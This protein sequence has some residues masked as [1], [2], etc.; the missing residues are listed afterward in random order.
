MRD[1]GVARSSE[2]GW[3]ATTIGLAR[4][5]AWGWEH[6]VGW[7]LR[8]MLLVPILGYQRF[9]SPLTPPSCRLHP[10]CSAYAVGSITVHGAVKGSLLTGWRL[11]RCNPWNRGGIDPV[12]VRGR[13]LPDV[14]PDGQPRHGTMSVHSID[15]SGI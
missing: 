13:W 15:G 14:L 2:S 1:T 5:V 7:L 9:V 8:W 10:S 12:P 3:A 4:R 11:L 6:S